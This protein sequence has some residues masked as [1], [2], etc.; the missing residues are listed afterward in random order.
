MSNANLEDKVAVVTGAAGAIGIATVQK[1]LER[2]AKVVAVD[3]KNVDYSRLLD[4]EMLD[5]LV[6][7]E[8]DVSDDISVRTYVNNALDAFGGK[9]DIFFN[10]AGIEGPVKPLHE[11]TIEEFRKVLSVNLEGVFLGLKYVL[12]VMIGQ[13]AGSIINTSSSGGG[14]MGSPGLGAYCASKHGVI[15]L[16][17]V[18]AVESG[19]SGVRVN[20]VNPGPI[21]SPMID[22]QDA[23]QGLSEATRTQTLPARRYGRPEEV[24]AVVCFLASDEASYV[25]GTFYTVDGGRHARA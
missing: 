4:P 24:A 20:C 9:I 8:A 6:I 3:Q 12:P 22:R 18:A 19:P 5:R 7:L 1:M 14:L 15:G 10:N 23:E 21:R 11:V 17:R 13:G 16:T 25:N 2:G